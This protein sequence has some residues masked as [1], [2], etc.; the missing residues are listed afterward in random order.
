MSKK[1]FFQK[2]NFNVIYF[3]FY[4]ITGIIDSIIKNFYHSSFDKKM[5][6]KVFF[7]PFGIL[8]LYISNIPDLLVLIP[9]FIRKKKLKNNNEMEK[10]KI[11]NLNVGSEEQ[12]ESNQLI[13]NYVKELQSVKKK[14]III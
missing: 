13:Y 12:N 8:L 2:C 11:S 7:L 14:L 9:Y 5:K 10:S 6:K 4:I 1:I 3:I